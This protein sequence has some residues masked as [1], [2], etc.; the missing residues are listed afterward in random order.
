M[1]APTATPG[2]HQT[3]ANARRARRCRARLARTCWSDALAFFVDKRRAR[4]SAA[5]RSSDAADMRSFAKFALL[6]ALIA[7][8]ATS[9]L[10]DDEDDDGDG[11]LLPTLICDA[12][13]RGEESAVRVWLGHASSHINARDANQE[14]TLLMCA[15]QEVNDV[16]LPTDTGLPG[17]AR[18][19]GL[20]SHDE[21]RMLAKRKL[22]VVDFLL[23]KGAA[24]DKQDAR[25]RSALIYASASGQ[26]E[27]V[28]MLLGGGAALELK[29]RSFVT[30]LIAAAISAHA[31]VVLALLAA[32]AS[33]ET[34]DADGKTALEWARSAQSHGS[35]HDE[36]V[37][38][39]E[40]AE[41]HSQGARAKPKGMTKG[42]AEARA[43]SKA[44]AGT[45]AQ[46]GSKVK[47]S[48]KAGSKP[49]TGAK[50]NKR[51]QQVKVEL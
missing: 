29:D 21:P 44:K 20:P 30:A 25:G 8:V 2:A 26:H 28:H 17:A 9:D 24:V 3:E 51:A 12:A 38:L 50:A 13:R 11:Y 41:G 45:K 36:V 48:A 23:H 14:E 1:Q 43:R 40:D 22:G 47:G 15:C 31:G 46:A 16:G 33:H 37:A 35:S 5:R 42:G 27:L 4:P 32:G 19:E 7:T 6:T 39:L 18:Q 49:K 34:F 10:D